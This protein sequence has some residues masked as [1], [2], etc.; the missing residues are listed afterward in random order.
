MEPGGIDPRDDTDGLKPV[1]ASL[2]GKFD[3]RL[4]E[5]KRLKARITALLHVAQKWAPVLR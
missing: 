2:L 4:D 1:A 5:I 3:S